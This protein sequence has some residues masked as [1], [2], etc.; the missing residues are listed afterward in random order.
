MIR[1]RVDVPCAGS[2]MVPRPLGEFRLGPGFLDSLDALEGADPQNVAEVV[3]HVVAGRAHQLHGLQVHQLRQ[4]LG[5]EARSGCAADRRQSVALCGPGRKRPRRGGCTGG[6]CPTARS[7]LTASLCTTTSRCSSNCRAFKVVNAAD[8]CR[9][10]RRRSATSARTRKA[11]DRR[12]P[13][14]CSQV[15]SSVPA[16]SPAA[17]TR[18]IRPFRPGAAFSFHTLCTSGAAL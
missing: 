8:G 14:C 2:R 9:S 18:S 17:S 4:S 7:S 3:C 6:C 12:T 13:G 1:S 11:C 5:G 10:S 15:R 16:S